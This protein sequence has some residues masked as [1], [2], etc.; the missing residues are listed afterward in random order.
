MKSILILGIILA[1]SFLSFG[2]TKT[3]SNVNDLIGKWQL[4]SV[5]IGGQNGSPEEV[6][7]QSEVFQVYSKNNVFESV[8]GSI[9]TKGTWELSKKDAQITVEI[10]EPKNKSIFKIK[11]FSIKKMTLTL[12]VQDGKV[13]VLNYEK[14]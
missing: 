8:M 1:T 6:F 2:Q 12:G 5:E 13:I 9:K 4:K 10:V 11:T 7:G 3:I 14:Q